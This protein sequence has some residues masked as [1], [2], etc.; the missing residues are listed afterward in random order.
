MYAFVSKDI[1]NG[2]LEK[3]RLKYRVIKLSPDKRLYTSIESHPDIRVLPIDNQ[4][5]IDQETY[6]DLNARNVFS[7][8]DLQ[9]I[10][11]IDIELSPIYPNTVFL[12]GKYKDHL[13]IHHKKY[14]HPIVGDYI[15]A[16]DISFIH[17][18]QGY[19]GCSL[20]LL[21]HRSGITSDAGI[22]KTLSRQ[23]MQIL[24]IQEGH[25]HLQDKP[26]GF[27]G[28]ASGVEG[29]QV[30]FNGNIK[31]HP[32]YKLIQEFIEDRGYTIIDNPQIP[33][34]DIGSILFWKGSV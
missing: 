14:T 33:L 27:I 9:G 8:K 21:D 31:K 25:I 30:F 20:L 23:G 29:K 3:L 2:L 24:K 4:L 22:Y 18:N 19:T 12:N 34:T 13:F 16:K 17:T 28:G 15:L 11:A 1:S 10:T 5:F 7:K 6:N 32:D 26:Y